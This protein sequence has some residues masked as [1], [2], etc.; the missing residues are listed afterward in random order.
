MRS[1]SADCSLSGAIVSMSMLLN[2]WKLF[3]TSRVQT[4]AETIPSL[5]A[6]YTALLLRNCTEP[7]VN[8]ARQ[9]GSLLTAKSPKLWDHSG[10][11]LSLDTWT[12]T[13]LVSRKNR[14]SESLI[15]T[16]SVWLHLQPGSKFRPDLMLWAQNQGKHN[17]C[18]EKAAN[19][20][21]KEA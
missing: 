16:T 5:P 17:N 11:S 14:C 21:Q 10:L 6:K 19:C 18:I 20:Q 9:R 7:E 8:Q 12:A 15:P 2:I 4:G 13:E 3:I 1:H